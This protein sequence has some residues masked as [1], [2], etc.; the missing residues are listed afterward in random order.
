M[1]VWKWQWT[2][3]DACTQLA[4]ASI[5]KIGSQRVLSGVSDW[6][7]TS[8]P[9]GYSQP[10]PRRGGGQPGNNHSAVLGAPSRD[11]RAWDKAG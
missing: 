7:V 10:F 6:R 3:W 11:L 8:C 2:G 1:W 9:W 5:V 4:G